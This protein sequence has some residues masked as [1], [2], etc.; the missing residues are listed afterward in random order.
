MKTENQIRKKLDRIED[1]FEIGFHAFSSTTE[2][3]M[4]EF[5]IQMDILDWVLGNP[6][7]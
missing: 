4:V 6:I 1:N 7:R 5:E 2:K 3:E